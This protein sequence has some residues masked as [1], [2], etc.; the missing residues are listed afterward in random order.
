MTKTFYEIMA[1]IL[2]VGGVG[3]INYI[4]AEQLN[5]IDTTQSGSNR[6]KAIALV[7]TM[8][9]YFLYLLMKLFWGLCLKGIPLLIVTCISTA[10]ISLL[11]SFSCS[12]WINKKFY[13]LINFV[14]VKNGMSFRRSSTNWQS[15]FDLNGAR[16]QLIY[17]YDFNHQPLGFGWR[18]G[19]SN[20]KESNYSVSFNPQ[21]DNNPED[22]DSYE[23]VTKLVQQ[24]NFQADFEV[25]EYVNFQQ[26]FIA[27]ICN[28]KSDKN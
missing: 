21:P 26:K 11:I 5:A 3:I 6:E 16:D 15:A 17:L 7:F 24:D 13:D 2:T 19:I 12:K 10:L 28:S 25:T 1:A 8:F 27:I 9:D 23:E 18:K 14:R 20:D 4:I 22:Q